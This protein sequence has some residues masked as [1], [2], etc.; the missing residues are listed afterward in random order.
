[1]TVVLEAGTFA[2]VAG[3]HAAGDTVF[4]FTDVM[5]SDLGDIMREEE[6]SG[7]IQQANHFAGFGGNDQLVMGGGNDLGEGGAG[8][9]LIRGGG[10][11]D[12]LRGGDGFDQLIGDAG[13]D[14]LTGGGGND[15]FFFGR[16]GDSTVALAGRDR[17]T[18]FSRSQGDAIN[19]NPLDARADVAGNQS[20]TFIGKAAFTAAGQL[21]VVDAGAFL[22][23]Q[24]N[25]DRDAGAEFAVR[26]DGVANLFA[27]DFIL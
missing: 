3:G 25:V 7:T 22:V 6:G 24:G 10:G 2:T 8:Q 11:R 15:T 17:I 26:V 16:L 18:D 19:V 1:V 5:G 13:S 23:V 20:F 14:V 27:G 21:R 4:G 12:T 9:D